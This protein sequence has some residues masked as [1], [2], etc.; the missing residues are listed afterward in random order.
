M[1]QN[2]CP[3]LLVVLE[4]KIFK[5][6]NAVCVRKYDG[7]ARCHF[8]DRSMLISHNF[9]YAGANMLQLVR[10]S[11]LSFVWF[12]LFVCFNVVFYKL[13][14]GSMLPQYMA[15][16]ISY[17]CYITFVCQK[18]FRTLLSKVGGWDLVCWLFSQI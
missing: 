9:E 17:V 5:K 12:Y 16:S 11:Q 4:C 15:L 6:I 7:S 1:L 10:K 3:T 2:L 13:F 8:P 18:T 14:I